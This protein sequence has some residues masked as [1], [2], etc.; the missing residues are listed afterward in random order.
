MNNIK[1]D[2]IVNN[3][4]ECMQLGNGLSKLLTLG[5]TL[6]LVGD[7]GSGKT[8]FVKGILLGFHYKYN[9]TSPT[10]TL[11]NEYN[12]DKKVVHMDFYRE[13]NLNRWEKIGFYDYINL[14]KNITIIEWSNLHQSLLPDN[15]IQIN[16][17]HINEDK[18]R[19]FTT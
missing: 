3:I 7:L 13:E 6:G 1:F 10:F 15:I 18:R 11:I 14:N 2:Q 17:E 5:D 4:E 8:T 16:F 19:I 9:V 12:A